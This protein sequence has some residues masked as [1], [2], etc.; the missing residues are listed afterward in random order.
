MKHDL[1]TPQAILDSTALSLDEKIEALQQLAYDARERE[2]AREE[3]MSGPPSQLAEI[4]AALRSLGARDRTSSD[5][6]Q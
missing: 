2:V 6:K 4:Q 1:S 5:A 3:G